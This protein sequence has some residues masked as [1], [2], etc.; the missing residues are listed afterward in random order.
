MKFLFD[1]LPIAL[2][3]GCFKYA[4]N[5]KDWAAAFATQH[6]GFMVSG[7]SVGAQQ[8]PV[9]LATVVVIVATLAQVAWLKLRGRKVDTMLWVSLV[10]VVVLGGLTIWF[11]NE[12]FIKWKPSVLYW[13]MGTALWLSPL[14]AGKNLL[15][16]MLGEQLQLPAKVWHRL[17]FAWVA[18][19]AGMGLLN[20]WV[21]Y[22]F[23]TD[24]WVNFKL[25]GGIGLMLVFTIAQGLYLSRHID[26]TPRAEG[27]PPQHTP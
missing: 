27:E 6:F 23:S 17:N 7:G 22:S 15:K 4:E 9:L 14:L 21:A 3:F 25:F 11:H 20:L 13:A 24:A 10:L 16:V 26:E 1:F 12:T 2:F 18:F 5:H 19:F 8:A